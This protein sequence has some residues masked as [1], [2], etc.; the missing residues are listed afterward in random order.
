MGRGIWVLLS[1]AWV[2]WMTSF[3]GGGRKEHT[4]MGAAETMSGC[5]C[6]APH[7]SS[8]DERSAAAA[9]V[10]PFKLPRRLVA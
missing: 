1:C 7:L 10:L 9:V 6:N 3:L 4:V 2:L 5:Q 8:G